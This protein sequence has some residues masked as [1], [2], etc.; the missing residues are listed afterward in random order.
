MYNFL[1]IETI[2][3]MQTELMW[4]IEDFCFVYVVVVLCDLSFS[5][6]GVIPVTDLLLFLP[7]CSWY[8]VF[9]YWT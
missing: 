8:W 7:S 6:L 1:Y 3:E 9:Q 4:N 2:H 5:F